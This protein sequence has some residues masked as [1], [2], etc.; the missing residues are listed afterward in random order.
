[1]ITALGLAIGCWL[2]LA[3][4]TLAVECLLIYA[5]LS[6]AYGE[7]VRRSYAGI[8]CYA[9][10]IRRSLILLCLFAIPGWP[11]SL[12][13]TARAWLRDR[14]TYLDELNWKGP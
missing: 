9:G 10:G 5:C 4:L 7:R 3:G 6:G 8:V 1:M 12:A 14:R 13:F 11:A 2:A